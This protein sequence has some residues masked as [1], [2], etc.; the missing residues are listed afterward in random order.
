MNYNDKNKKGEYTPTNNFYKKIVFL[1]FFLRFLA[2]IKRE[3]RK[4]RLFLIPFSY[5]HWNFFTP[6]KT[7]FKFN[8]KK[9]YDLAQ[10]SSRFWNGGKK[11]RE[12]NGGWR[13]LPRFTLHT[14][15]INSAP[16]ELYR[17]PRVL[18][19]RFWLRPRFLDIQLSVSLLALTSA[20]VFVELISSRRFISFASFSPPFSLF[21]FS[22]PLVCFSF[23]ISFA[24]RLGRF[25]AEETKRKSEQDQEE[26]YRGFLGVP[27]ELAPL[28][29]SIVISMGCLC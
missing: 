16:F 12:R 15:L 13:E 28:L 8:L 11:K 3:I 7:C 6:K 14:R 1:R 5:Y 26:E 19:S 17:V 27:G 21:L 4:I 23:T 18:G 20:L 22:S 29:L 9:R 10:R 2:D 24:I 25:L